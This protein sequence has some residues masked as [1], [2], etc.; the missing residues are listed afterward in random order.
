MAN[1]A[2]AGTALWVALAPLPRIFEPRS[3]GARNNIAVTCHD[4]LLKLINSFTMRY[5]LSIAYQGTHYHGWQAQ[6]NATTVQ[7]I[8]QDKLTQLL[9]QP[10]EI[11]GSSRTD[12]GVHAEQQWAH[13][14][15]PFEVNISKLQYN[16]NN[17][18]PPD[19]AIGGIYPVVPT[20]HARYAAI[21]RTYVYKIART[22]NPFLR[23]TTYTFRKE[24]QIDQMNEAAAILQQFQNFETFSKLGSPTKYPY[25]CDIHEAYWQVSADGLTFQITANRFLRGMVRAVV[26]NLLEVG[27][28]SMTVADFQSI[29][30]S[31]DRSLSAGLVPAAGLTLTRVTYPPD[32]FVGDA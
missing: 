3:D 18:L 25:L 2:S 4:E 1:V 19:I 7:G 6:A 16:L 9:S 12:T 5:F 11:V 22:K 30:A 24:L 8:I 17:I 28:G 21:S 26:G 10:I 32:V 13:I 23:S 15:F 31:Q 27:L 29:I 20:A 14:D